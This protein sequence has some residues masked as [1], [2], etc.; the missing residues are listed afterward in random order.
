MK[1]L[2]IDWLLLEINFLIDWL[3]EEL[4]FFLLLFVGEQLKNE[5]ERLDSLFF[6]GDTFDMEK[7]ELLEG[8]WH[9]LDSVFLFKICIY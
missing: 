7:D 3:F 6:Y 2:F 9:S 4:L 8:F 5:F 1:K